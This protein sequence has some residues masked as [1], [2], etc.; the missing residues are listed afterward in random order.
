M[1]GREFRMDVL[2]RVAVVPEEELFSALEEAQGA[3]VIEERG[4]VGGVVTFWFTHAFF[5]QTLYEETFTPRR[6]RLHRQVG[7]A[8]EEVYSARLEEHASEMAEHFSNSSD[9]VGLGKALSYGEMAAERA[10]GVYA[11]SEAAGHLE[12]C[13][14]VHGVLSPDDVERRRDLLLSLG[15]ALM[16][17]GE[18]RRVYETVAAEAFALAEGFADRPRASRACRAALDAINRYGS[19]TMMGSPEYRQWAERADLYAEPGTTDRV[20]ADVAQGGRQFLEGNL[21]DAWALSVRALELARKLN[22][23][24]ALHLAATAFILGTP[25][26][27]EEERWRLVT[28][29]AAHPHAG[30][31]PR[32]LGQWL[33]FSVYAYLD[34]GERAGAEGIAEEL[35]GLA[36]RT[37]DATLIVR[38]LIAPCRFAFLDGRLEGAVSAA[39]RQLEKAEELGAPAMGQTHFTMG[40]FRPLLY[41]GRGDEALAAMG[42]TARLA[43]AEDTY[44]FE[45]MSVMLRAHVASLDDAEYGL[46]RLMTKHHIAPDQENLAAHLLV[47]LLET[48]V[49]IEDRELCSVLAQ[50][51]APAAFLSNAFIA[52]TCPARHLGAAAALLGESEKARAYYHRGLEAAGKIPFRPEIA[53]IRLQ[54]AELLLEH[55]P[56]ER[57]EAL[58]H[59]D[60]AIGEFR[61]MKMQPS[62][63]RALSHRDILKGVICDR[64]GRSDGPH[65][66]S[67]DGPNEGHMV[68][69]LAASH[70]GDA[71][72]PKPKPGKVN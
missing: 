37:Q 40:S 35:S 9:E 1:I 18:P 6:I 61:D 47:M 38:S 28:E 48:A 43:E 65:A 32:T 58:E 34:W 24:E 23:P 71:E 21:T 25:I 46:R 16:P 59:L 70:Q 41:L 2:G 67:R 26:Q 62:L 17:T 22:D 13:L 50:K 51:L 56:D 55:Y 19:A 29:M 14:Q 60:F 53:L 54:L 27:H 66:A 49:L 8:L 33:H 69:G 20:F 30:V 52:Y 7:E 42:E 39:E 31:A 45:S 68:M 72:G 63:E 5:R 44:L 64:S 12:R 3:A 4:T 36:D 57:P 10:M 11:Y 15:E